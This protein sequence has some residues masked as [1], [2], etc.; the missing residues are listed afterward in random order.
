MKSFAVLLP[1]LDEE[2]DVKYKE[3]HLAHLKK[4]RTRGNVY[5]NGRFADG[6]GGL[7][8]Y[9][10]DSLEQVIKLI[11]LDPYVIQGARSYEIHEW[12]A[13]LPAKNESSTV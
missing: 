9:L 13:A 11:N 5:T 6:T 12:N 7:V 8:I 3:D 10:G 1:M 2:K 4:M